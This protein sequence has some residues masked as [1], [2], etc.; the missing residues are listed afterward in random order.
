M[1]GQNLRRI[2]TVTLAAIF[3]ALNTLIGG[4]DEAMKI[5][6]VFILLDIL[7]GWMRAYI[8][9]KL[10]SNESFRGMAKKVLVLMIVAVAA[11]GDRM[12]GTDLLRKATCAF[13]CATETLSILENCAAVDVL[14]PPFLRDALGEIANKKKQPTE[15][16]TP[17]AP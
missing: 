2:A 17:S 10:S 12:A 4:W 6:L 8:Q 5:L 11:L 15:P 14:V 9:K 16:P 3:A 7:S 13:Y 1:S